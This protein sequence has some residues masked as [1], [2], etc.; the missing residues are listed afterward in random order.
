MRQLEFL[1][2]VIYIKDEI[3]NTQYYKDDS[4]KY[5]YQGSDGERK[6]LIFFMVIIRYP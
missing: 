5:D 2:L 4:N 6:I 1:Q 3:L